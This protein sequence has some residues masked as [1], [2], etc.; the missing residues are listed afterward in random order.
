MLWLVISRYKKIKK[1]YVFNIWEGYLVL[2]V[3]KEN[4][5]E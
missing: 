2:Y 3:E 4:L 1:K 5:N